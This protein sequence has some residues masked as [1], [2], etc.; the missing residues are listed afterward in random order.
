MLSMVFLNTSIF[1]NPV[2]VNIFLISLIEEFA[3]TAIIS[4]QGSITSLVF[5]S[6]KSSAFLK[7][8][9]SVSTFSLS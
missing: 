5:K 4:V 7:I 8:S 1:D 3:S 6:E 9:I 2:F